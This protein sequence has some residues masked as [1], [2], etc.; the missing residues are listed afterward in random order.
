MPYIIF[1]SEVIDIPKTEPVKNVCALDFI[2]LFSIMCYPNDSAARDRIAEAISSKNVL[3]LVE[4]ING[5]YGDTHEILVDSELVLRLA[6]APGMMSTVGQ[7]VEDAAFGGALAGNVLG[8]VPFRGE[9]PETRATASLGSAFRMIEEATRAGR[10]RDREYEAEY[11]A[12]ISAG[13]SLLGSPKHM[14]RYGGLKFH[15]G[16]SHAALPRDGRVLTKKR[17]NFRSA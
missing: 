15:D 5:Q 10:R 12:D 4:K 17:R 8:W 13:C 1:P 3:S 16:K 6:G 11:M 14:A 7:A 2:H 9:R